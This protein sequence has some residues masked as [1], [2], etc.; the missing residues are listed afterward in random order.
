MYVCPECIYLNDLKSHSD[1]FQ[2]YFINLQDICSIH[3]YCKIWE[4]KELVVEAVLIN[5]ALK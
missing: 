2:I 1:S 5:F 4:I 3:F